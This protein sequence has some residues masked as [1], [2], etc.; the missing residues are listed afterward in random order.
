MI[1]VDAE[2]DR[3]VQAA[4]DPGDYRNRRDCLIRAAVYWPEEMLRATRLSDPVNMPIICN[5]L[6]IFNPNAEALA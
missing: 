3:L 5:I 2:L 1:P 4:L 6:D